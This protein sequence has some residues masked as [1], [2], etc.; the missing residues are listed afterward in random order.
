MRLRALRADDRPAL[1][2]LLEATGVFTAEELMVAVELIDGGDCDGYRFQ[3]A[4]EGGVVAGYAC[5]GR[6]WFTETTW[7]LYWIAAD[8][9]RQGRSVGSALLTAAETAAA[10]EGGRMMLIERASRPS[11]APSRRFFDNHGYGEIARVPDFYADGDDKIIYAKWL[12][13]GTGFPEPAPAVRVGH[14]P[15][16][17][18]GVF[19]LRAFKAGETIE[20]APVIPFPPEQWRLMDQSVLEEVCF[21]WGVDGKDGAVG[22]GFA[23]IY[24]HSFTPNARYIRRLDDLHLEYVA[25]RD[26]E[27]GEEILTNYNCEPDDM[28][29]VWFEP[30]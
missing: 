9:G 5:Y 22:L 29:P 17:G 6:A 21:C 11:Y 14:S 10:A 19:A 16:R 27:T 1:Q 3:V 4:E 18:R 8:R 20:R 23:S 26:I 24:N 25:L 2:A 13:A 28:T 30:V 12:A 15:G 7:D